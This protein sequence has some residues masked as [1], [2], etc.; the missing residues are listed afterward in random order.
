[1][2]PRVINLPRKINTDA[3]NNLTQNR[4]PLPPWSV[5]DSTLRGL[6]DSGERESIVKILPAFELVKRIEWEISWERILS[7]DILLF[8]EG[9]GLSRVR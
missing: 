8:G 6:I 9:K 2:D 3:L 5:G 4:F 1:M 7:G